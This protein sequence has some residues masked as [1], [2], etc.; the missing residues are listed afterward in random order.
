MFCDSNFEAGAR[1]SRLPTEEVED[2][3]AGRPDKR[4]AMFARCCFGE[5]VERDFSPRSRL[6]DGV[7]D[8]GSAVIPAYRH[9]H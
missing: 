3:K 7:S 1:F 5:T 8:S 4:L 9:A 2:I 6:G